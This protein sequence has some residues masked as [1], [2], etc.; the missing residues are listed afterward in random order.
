MPGI[1]ILSDYGKLSKQSEHL[2]FDD[3][4]REIKARAA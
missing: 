1:Y 2:V 3:G 4:L